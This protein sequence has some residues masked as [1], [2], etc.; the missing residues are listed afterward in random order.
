MKAGAQS[1]IM[2][3]AWAYAAQNPVP[4]IATAVVAAAA[5]V[6]VSK[7]LGGKPASKKV[8]SK[9]KPLDFKLVEKTI[10]SHDT[11]VF[12]FA[13]PTPDSILGLPIGQHVMVS[14]TI[15]GEQVQRSYTPISS[16]D[17]KGFV[18][19]CIKVY[20]AGVHPKFPDGGVMSQY[21]DSLNVGDTLTFRGPVGRW[22]YKGRGITVMRGQEKRVKAF[23]MI[24]GGTGITPVLQVMRAV[25]K[26]PQ[27][28]T[29]MHVLFANQ[30]E[31][32]ILLRPE[33]EEAAKDP[34]VKL[35][36]TVDRPPEGW[37]YSSGF[38]NADMLAEHMPKPSDDT[39]ILMCGPPIMITAAC[40]PNLEKNGFGAQHY[41]VF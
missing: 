5:L 13:L 25:L 22:E 14:A 16:D 20:K 7:L 35:H 15:K 4:A 32:D 33:L 26:D 21:M 27:D 9:D 3:R 37:K 29:T 23:G 17:D 40:K 39:Q 36:Y 24:A 10:V 28:R 30:S 41:V 38:I 8:L 18:D 12:R 19:L 11:R 1:A 2:E 6:V 34:R 31:A